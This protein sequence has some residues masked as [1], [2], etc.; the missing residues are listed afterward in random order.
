[1]IPSAVFGSGS[2]T[3]LTAKASLLAYAGILEDMNKRGNEPNQSRN[4]LL[5]PERKV[6]AKK[7]DETQKTQLADSKWIIVI[8]ATVLVFFCTG[9]YRL[10]DGEVQTYFAHM[11]TGSLQ[12]INAWIV[13]LFTFGIG[14]AVITPILLPPILNYL[15]HSKGQ[16]R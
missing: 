13:F 15:T 10:F 4:P 6:W 11:S 9:G 5:R 7:L 3:L 14:G 2:G 16:R 12:Q 8:G 1:L